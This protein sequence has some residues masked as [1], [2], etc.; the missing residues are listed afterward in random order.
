MPRVQH[1]SFVLANAVLVT[2]AMV[3]TSAGCVSR[4]TGDRRSTVPTAPGSPAADHRTLARALKNTRAVQSGRLEVATALT[5]L[6]DQPDPPPGGRVIVARYRVAF[7]RRA[8]RVAVEA[9]MSAAA[10]VL[11]DRDAAAGGD[12]PVVA[13][14]VAAGE[15]VHA[16]GGPPG[17][18]GGRAPAG[19]VEIDRAALVD[20]G[21]NSDAAALVLDPLG[22]FRVLDDV[23]ADARAVGHDEIRGSPVTHLAANA[24]SG[25][26]A[27]PVDVWI[28]ADGVIRR[29]EIRLAGGVGAGAGELV[30]TVEL[31]AV[32]R[33]V[34]IAPPVGQR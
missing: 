1:R 29:M 5:H 26:A 4:S 8:Q 6:G 2:A 31:F 13:R 17:A 30:T 33:A 27:V 11:A 7:D 12:V 15:V 18:A 20:R 32:G 34:D 23:T 3:L 10:G 14:L 21:P 16:Q 24:A 28:D 19:W 22:P 25:G 9:D